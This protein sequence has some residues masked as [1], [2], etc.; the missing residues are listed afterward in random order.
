[1]NNEVEWYSTQAH[2]ALLAADDNIRLGHYATA[3]N[4]AYYA[5]FYAANALLATKGIQRAKHSGVLAAFRQE[6]VKTGLIEAEYSDSYGSA[7][8]ARH[9]SDYAV[10]MN[11]SRELTLEY[12]KDAQR[13][14]T[15]VE[16]YLQ[17]SEIT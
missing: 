17:K 13:F 8:D 15:R 10:G 11:I 14:V 12:L 9:E 7:M 4:R 5:M 6:F 1:V 2:E 16:Q 3:L